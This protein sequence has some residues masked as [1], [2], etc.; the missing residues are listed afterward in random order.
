MLAIDT[1]TIKD[2]IM[3]KKASEIHPDASKRK[4]IIANKASFNGAFIDEGK[5]SLTGNHKFYIVGDKLELILK[6]LSFKI[7]DI[8]GHY[9]KYG[10]DFLDNE[11]F[12][13]LPDVRKLKIKDIDELKFYKLIGLTETEIKLFDKNY[14]EKKNVNDNLITNGE[15]NNKIKVKKVIRINNDN[16]KNKKIKNKK[17]IDIIV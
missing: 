14:T 17:S 16:S 15:N 5:L 7:I 11:A 12:T 9:T 13:Y 4:L 6:M 8:I 2:G 10:Q 1:Y 3:I